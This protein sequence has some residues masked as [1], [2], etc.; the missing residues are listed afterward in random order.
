MEK[1]RF[2]EQLTRPLLAS[3]LMADN[4]DDSIVC[5]RKSIYD[6]ADILAMHT[7]YLRPNIIITKH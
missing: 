4:A 5:I 3:M 7:E 2:S 1:P 6:G